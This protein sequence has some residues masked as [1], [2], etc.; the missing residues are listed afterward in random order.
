[1]HMR[2]SVRLKDGADH[3]SMSDIRASRD[4][5][6]SYKSSCPAA[7]GGQ[8]C[9]EAKTKQKLGEVKSSKQDRTHV[10]AMILW[11]VRYEIR[12]ILLSTVNYRAGRCFFY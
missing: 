10:V 8:T 9:V 4:G 1:M 7:I 11:N 2:Y 5:I 12:R 6:Y 3:E